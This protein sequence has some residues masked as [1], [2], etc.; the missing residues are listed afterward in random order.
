M[1]VDLDRLAQNLEPSKTI[2]FFGAGSSIP[3]G[4]PSATE[5][6]AALSQQF[7]IQG[8]GYSLS[9]LAELAELNTSRA[10]LISFLRSQFPRPSP[11]GGLLNMPLYDWKG[12]YTTNYDE[13]LE[14]SYQIRKAQ[15]YVIT[16]NYDFSA[17]K[18]PLAQPVYKI[19]GTIGKD[20]S[21]GDK[22]R[23]IITQGDYDKAVEYRD[24]LFTRLAADMAGADLVIIGYSLS[25]PDIKA[26]VDR[27]LA[28]QQKMGG[29]GGQVYLLLYQRDEGRA[30]LFEAR[31]VRVSFGG[32]DEFSEA[33][34]RKG[35][36]HA[37]VFTTSD[38]P[39]HTSKTLSA[40][41]V[42]VSHSLSAL[43]SNPSAMFNGRPATYADIREGL[44]FA[45]TV[46]NT[47]VGA[48]RAGSKQFFTILGASGVG[49]TTA[50]RQVC[51]QV[52]SEGW[53]CWEHKS[54][55][56][57]PVAEW[58]SAAEKLQ[59]AERDAVLLIDDAF[60]HVV[61]M[62]QLVDSMQ[63]KGLTRLRLLAT[64][65]RAQWQYRSKSIFLTKNGTESILSRL[66]SQE[67]DRLIL[68]V[69]GSN[70]LSPLVEATFSGFS[71]SEKRKRL[72]DRCEADAFVCLR[73][74]FAQEKF[75]DIILREYAQLSEP[76]QE[77]YRT[78][79]A[80][81]HIGIRVHRQLALRITG[82]SAQFVN[83]ALANLVDVLTEYDISARFGVFGWKVRHD[84]I[85]AIIT[86]YKFANPTDRLQLFEKV[87]SN[88]SPTYEVERQSI[89][90][91]CNID[92][93]IPSIPDKDI[94][95]RLFRT[96]ISIAPGEAV[97]RHRLIRN[98]IELEK[99]DLAETEIRVFKSDIGV[100]GPVSRYG[101]ALLLARAQYTPG[102][103]NED[104]IV[105]LQEAE[106][107]ASLAASRYSNNR[108]VLATYCDVGLEL[109]RRTGDETALLAAMKA[110]KEAEIR[111]G[112]EEIS[113]TLRNY[114][115]KR[116]DFTI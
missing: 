97:P 104:R 65:G 88:L 27:V 3:S 24:F 17:A 89:N 55:F 28:I 7:S 87:I 36:Q 67:I 112:D 106:S 99:F 101:V 116:F 34:A 76:D 80:M 81:Q 44:T 10:D 69:S 70:A 23:I 15:Y 73:N 38:D 9:E 93:G 32:I 86:K 100:D 42:D 12:I 71:F 83:A 63:S 66:N 61:A 37:V 43:K 33:L 50:A 77:A 60:L 105:I 110:L 79:S 111:T 25:D 102:L 98:L 4:S 114:E 58:V 96:L 35:P 51:A 92:T 19:H 48:F 57:L 46:A 108:N 47:A 16:T 85:A 68:L 115:R 20:V 49:K 62:S 107:K 18:D 30:R 84:V 82:I 103:M 53:L 54:D 41:A 5:L 109:L 113:R 56:A 8:E 26:V 59:S 91:M 1:P 74:I 40:T 29:A 64:S 22:S 90:E 6:S 95:N 31:G 94:Q 72:A 75:D 14:R 2:L 13:L 52:Q 78:V 45:R 21:S 39:T 11:T